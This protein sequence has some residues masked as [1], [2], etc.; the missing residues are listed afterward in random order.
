M[1]ALQAVT[2]IFLLALLLSPVFLMCYLM[3][4]SWQ[5]DCDYQQ[6]HERERKL[7]AAREKDSCLYDLLRNY[8]GRVTLLQYAL[9]SGLS[10]EES[11]THLEARAVD[12][13]AS[14]EFNHTGETVYQF[15]TGESSSARLP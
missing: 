10:A 4:R 1:I 6:E 12:F 3:Y 2:L 15:I 13:G 11:R 5:L 7:R 8:K 14:V 9:E